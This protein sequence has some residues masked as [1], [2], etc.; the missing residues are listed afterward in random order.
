MEDVIGQP[1]CIYLYLYVR[2]LDG[3]MTVRSHNRS[4][5][6]YDVAGLVDTKK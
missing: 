6:G 5:T 1:T 3:V 4:E 2:V